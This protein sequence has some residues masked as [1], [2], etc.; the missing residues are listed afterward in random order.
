MLG[1]LK[2]LTA[3]DV[4]D[5]IPHSLFAPDSRPQP[6]TP[7]FDELPDL[8]EYR[9]VADVLGFEPPQIREQQTE[10][11]RRGLIGFMLDN[12]FPIYNNAEVHNYMVHLAQRRG[13][14]FVWKRLDQTKGDP[15]DDKYRWMR[16]PSERHGIAIVREEK[17]G[18][19]LL[20]T[21]KHP[22][23]LDILKRAALVKKHYPT[24]EIYVSDYAVHDPDPFICAKYDACEH[25][26]F[27]VWDEPGFKAIG[28]DAK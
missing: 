22:V 2:R 20:N 14:I 25:V 16:D 23:P 15:F 24:A 5:S 9:E 13:K 19:F 21:Y 17:H 7:T 12:G 18:Q 11:L 8:A 10:R 1:I 27:G 3:A 4:I 6:I 28:R 26:V